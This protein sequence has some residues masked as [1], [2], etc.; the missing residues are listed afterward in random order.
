MTKK[1]FDIELKLEVVRMIK[2]QGLSISNVS[3]TMDV[4]PTAIRR[5]VT[6]HDAE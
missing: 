5:W 3:K 2:D 1:H 4:R 6:Q